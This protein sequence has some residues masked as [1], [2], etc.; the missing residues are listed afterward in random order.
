MKPIWLLAW[1]AAIGQIA[2]WTFTPPPPAQ[3]DQPG[4]QV[5][6][7]SN[8]DIHVE[9]RVG[10]RKQAFAALELPWGG[11]CQGEVRKKFIAGLN[12][13]YYHRQNQ[14]ERYPET[15]GRAGADYIATQWSTTDDKRIDRLMQEAYARGY[16]RLQDFNEVARRMIGAVVQQER[17]T[18]KACDS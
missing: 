12:E 13:Y 8:E 4:Q 15:F 5:A 14:T 16:V 1:A 17:I 10:L 18:T 3:T 11:R 2:A 9:S 6:F 7:G